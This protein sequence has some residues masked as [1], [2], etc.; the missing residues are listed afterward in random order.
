MKKTT[1]VIVGSA[2]TMAMCAS[3]IAGSTF[4]LFTSES[5]TSI[6][7]T[8]GKVSVTASA[9]LVEAYSVKPEG[10]GYTK[11]P[12]TV[13]GNKAT[14]T[15]GGTVT[16][17]SESNLLDIVNISS[18]DGAKLKVSIQNESSINI[19]Y[20]LSVAAGADDGLFDGLK[21]TVS[22][23]QEGNEPYDSSWA[24]ANVGDPI[25][26]LY[27]NVEL[28]TDAGNEY[29]DKSC[30][31]VCTVYAMQS[32]AHVTEFSA[33]SGQLRNTLGNGTSPSVELTSNVT[34]GADFFMNSEQVSQTLDLNG[35]T[36]RGSW[37]SFGFDSKAEAPYTHDTDIY[38]RNGTIESNTVQTTGSNGFGI[39]L[40]GARETDEATVTLHLDNVRVSGTYVGLSTNGTNKGV[41]IIANNCTFEGGLCG[42]YL[43]A[44]AE[45]EFNNCTFIGMSGICAR[46]GK[47]T[48]NDC[49]VKGQGEYDPFEY[50]PS[51]KN[52]GN[53]SAILIPGSD[54]AYG[55]LELTIN[56][57][58][59]VSESGYGI[60]ELC[61][62]PLSEGGASYPDCH[63]TSLVVKD[64]AAEC[65]LGEMFVTD[66]KGASH[67]TNRAKWKLPD[68]WLA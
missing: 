55:M 59:L 63:L 64:T 20:K 7:V 5:Q 28:P 67:D 14:F 26:D 30:T 18:G 22:T 58:K 13:E 65:P 4:A 56:G 40:F 27:V 54:S 48:L 52:S 19:K 31:I 15:N 60:E 6:A 61:G 33:G 10:G 57:G 46:A 50:F 17:L 23:D 25:S 3:L 42:V 44:D 68:G 34:S 51:G 29:K 45:C 16:Y 43:P 66:N 11:D 1:K 62:L 35:H 2:L 32:N 41:K 49:T 12:R 37:H 47:V 36:L 53:G 24:T 8:S 9:E 38:I 21:V 39:S